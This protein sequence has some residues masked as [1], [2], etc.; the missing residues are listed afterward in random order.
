MVKCKYCAQGFYRICLCTYFFHCLQTQKL[1]KTESKEPK[2]M[3]HRH[4]CCT[5]LLHC[6]SAPR[7]E[8][9][10]FQKK[11]RLDWFFSDQQSSCNN[12]MLRNISTEQSCPAIMAGTLRMD[13]MDPCCKRLMGNVFNVLSRNLLGVSDMYWF[14]RTPWTHFLEIFLQQRQS[15]EMLG[16]EGEGANHSKV[17]EICLPTLVSELNWGFDEPKAGKC[18]SKEPRQSIESFQLKIDHKVRVIGE[19]DTLPGAMLLC[20]VPIHIIHILQ[21]FPMQVSWVL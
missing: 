14:M 2:S 16:I 5:Y 17:N 8:L 21:C 10:I 7:P 15:W 12:I 9:L 4:E 6:R 20:F 3:K 1:T 11:W 18:Q 13:R 19:R